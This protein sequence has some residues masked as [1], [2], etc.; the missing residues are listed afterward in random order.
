MLNYP[1]IE[2]PANIDA[3]VI[4]FYIEFDGSNRGM[5][6]PK[7]MSPTAKLEITCSKRREAEAQMGSSPGGK[8]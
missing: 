7:S 5:R 1:N 2:S 6:G 8:R 4:L 3:S